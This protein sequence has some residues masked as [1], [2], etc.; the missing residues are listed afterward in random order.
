MNVKSLKIC[1]SK[2]N[3]FIYFNSRKEICYRFM[4]NIFAGRSENSHCDRRISCQEKQTNCHHLLRNTHP[5]IGVEPLPHMGC[6][7]RL[8]K[9]EYKPTSVFIHQ[10]ILFW[11]HSYLYLLGE[12]SNNF[13]KFKRKDLL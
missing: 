12:Y 13:S 3:V 9:Y 4:A 7:A 2:N 10:S 8:Q 6:S 1:T 11:P 5:A